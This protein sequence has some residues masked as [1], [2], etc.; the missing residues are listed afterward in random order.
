MKSIV[1]IA[2]SIVLMLCASLG[3]AAESAPTCTALYAVKEGTVRY[4]ASLVT[5]SPLEE[6]GCISVCLS[7][8]EPVNYEIIAI[9]VYINDGPA[10]LLLQLSPTAFY[11]MLEIPPH[12]LRSLS[13]VPVAKTANAAETVIEE[14]PSATIA[15]AD[16]QKL[17]DAAQ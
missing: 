14:L 3:M 12:S 4:E 15:L 7:Y 10:Q 2:L 5:C 9:H 16:F 17:E 13:I 11:G 6:Y 1:S 8:Q